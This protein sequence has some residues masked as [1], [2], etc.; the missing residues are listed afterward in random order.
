MLLHGNNHEVHE[1]IIM[2]WESSFWYFLMYTLRTDSHHWFSF[3]PDLF[4]F[5]KRSDSVSPHCRFCCCFVGFFPSFF[6]LPSF[7]M[8][9]L[10]LSSHQWDLG[11][12]SVY[13]YRKVEEKKIIPK[14]FRVPSLFVLSPGELL[15]RRV[16]FMHPV[17]SIFGGSNFNQATVSLGILPK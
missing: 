1:F 10:F 3:P 13:I 5:M 4:P 12:H 2:L 17:V 14:C 6:R 15:C 11:P 9:L 16:W 8:I 7:S